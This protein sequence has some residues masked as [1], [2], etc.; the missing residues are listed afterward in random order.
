MVQSEEEGI[1]RYYLVG[2]AQFWIKCP[3]SRQVS[4]I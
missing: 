1:D 2:D 4:S 3:L